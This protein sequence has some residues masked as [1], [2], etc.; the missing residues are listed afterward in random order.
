M[1]DEID[2]E[3]AE[4]KMERC[5]EL[6]EEI[7]IL[8]AKIDAKLDAMGRLNREAAELLGEDPDELFRH[9]A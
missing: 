1:T 4:A 7:E 9:D 3:A 8:E 6:E 2:I 5:A